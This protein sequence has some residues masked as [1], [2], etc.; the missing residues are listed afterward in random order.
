[1]F[2]SSIICFKYDKI[3]FYFPRLTMP[4]QAWALCTPC[5]YAAT[6]IEC[7]LPRPRPDRPLKFGLQTNN[8][9]NNVA[10]RVGLGIASDKIT[11]PHSEWLHFSIPDSNQSR[12][13]AII[14]PYLFFRS[15]MTNCT[16][17]ATIKRGGGRAAVNKKK[18]WRASR[19]AVP[20]KP[21]LQR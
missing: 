1:M 13:L 18:K 21:R 9:N 10:V 11:K 6:W 5:R 7:P 16:H 2:V 14:N 17:T 15:A 3:D 20:C 8:D 19:R 12:G 4:L